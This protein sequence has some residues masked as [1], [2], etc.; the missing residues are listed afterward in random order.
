MVDIVGE[1]SISMD[2]GEIDTSAVLYYLD[3]DVPELNLKR[4]HLFL[5]VNT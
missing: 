5:C 2:K 1:S 4:T 3:E